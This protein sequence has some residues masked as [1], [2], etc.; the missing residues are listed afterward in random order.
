MYHTMDFHCRGDRIR[1]CDRLFPKQE[2]YR[3]ALHPACSSL[4]NCECKGK[5]YFYIPK[6]F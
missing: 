4:L 2:R 1:T 6:I 5:I 3:A